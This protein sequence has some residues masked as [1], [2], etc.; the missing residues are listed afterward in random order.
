MALPYKKEFEDNIQKPLLQMLAKK[1]EMGNSAKNLTMSVYE[2][3]VTPIGW[4]STFIASGWLF[5][6]WQILLFT[7]VFRVIW[8]F[9]ICPIYCF[10]IRTLC[11]GYRRGISRFD[12]NDN[13]Y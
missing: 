7:V 3:F 5:F 12:Y 9:A 11:W 1:D 10:I 8:K 6:I 2:L 4:L 13:Y